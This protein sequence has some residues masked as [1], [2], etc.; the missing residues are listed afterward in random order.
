MSELPNIVVIMTDQQR[1]DVS[2]REGFPLDTTPFLDDMARGGTWFDRAYTS[3]PVCVPARES[4]LTG[5]FPSAHRVRENRGGEYATYER[6]MFDVMKSQG[7]ATALVGKN[8]SHLDQSRADHW[9]RFYHDGGREGD[10]PT[11]QEKAFDRWLVELNHAVATEPTPFP[12]ECQILYRAVSHAQD[13]IRSLGG[14]E[15]FFLW[16]SFPEPHNPYQVPEPYFSLFDPEELPPVHAGKEAL[17]DK[18]FKWQWTRRLGEYSYPDYEE[19]IPRARSNYFGLMRLIDDQV[20]RFVGFLEAEGL[21][22][23]T[24]IVF[25]SD[26]GDFVGEYGLTR[27]GPEMPEVLMR[28]PLLIVGPEVRANAEPHPAHVSIVDLLPTFCDMMG[29]PIPA[30]VQGRSLWPLLSGGEYPP[31]EFASIYAEQGYGGL[32][33]TDDDDPDFEHAMEAGPVNLTGLDL[34]EEPASIRPTFDEMNTYSQSGTMRMVRK[35]DWKLVLDMQGHGQMYD[36][37]R[38]PFELTNLYGDPDHADVQL[39]L[40]T[41]LLTWM[42]R[43]QDPLP[44]PKDRYIMKTDPRNYWTPYA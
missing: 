11:A 13:W 30:G 31:E 18:G 38:D 7:Y 9:V 24:L 37:A 17:E 36:L 44:L 3:A 41:E 1:A 42:L 21:R 4:F 20:K 40:S 14:E 27:K 5:R 8:H 10:S 15:P 33:Y 2:A 35:G 43:A 19:L 12:V 25:L 29:V 32:H 16:L 39:E 6:D 28:I 34:G 22:E 26:H 23:D